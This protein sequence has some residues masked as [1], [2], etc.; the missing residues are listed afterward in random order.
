MLWNRRWIRRLVGLGFF[1]WADDEE[2]VGPVDGRRR[3]EMVKSE[4]ENFAV[5]LLESLV[6]GIFR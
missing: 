4:F 5:I 6:T 3:L 2:L 1:N